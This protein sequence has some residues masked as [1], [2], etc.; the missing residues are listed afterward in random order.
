LGDHPTA[1]DTDVYRVRGLFH[2]FSYQL[3]QHSFSYG[4]PILLWPGQA[5]GAFFSMRT[6]IRLRC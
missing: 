6:N 3:Q 1:Q 5:G 4:F 2:S